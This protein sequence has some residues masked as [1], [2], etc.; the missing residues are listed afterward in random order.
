MGRQEMLM[1]VLPPLD[2]EK[3][4]VETWGDV[5][6]QIKR[7]GV[8]KVTKGLV[9]RSSQERSRTWDGIFRPVRQ[10]DWWRGDNEYHGPKYTEP[11][12]ELE[13]RLKAGEFVV[14]CE[15]APPRA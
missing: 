5:T 6:T 8:G 15:I 7:M 10:P 14:A 3:A 13:R 12:S 2:W 1:E 4:G 9:S 11:A